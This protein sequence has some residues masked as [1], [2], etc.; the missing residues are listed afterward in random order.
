MNKQLH[1]VFAFLI[2]LMVSGC[3]SAFSTQPIETPLPAVKSVTLINPLGPLAI[4]ATGITSGLV[5]GE[6]QVNVQNWKTI[7]EA[8]GLL[9]SDQAQFAALPITNAANMQASG[10]NLTL[11]GVHEWKVFYLLASAKNEFRDW[12]SLIGKIIYLPEAKGQTVDILTRYALA[13]EHISE[14]DVTFVYAPPQEIVALFKEGKVE[15]TALPEPFV[16]QALAAAPGK[17]VLDYQ[18]YWSQVSGAKEGIPV[19]GLFVKRDFMARYPKV[20]QEVAQ[21]FSESITWAN[22]HPDDA[23]RVSS[24]ILPFPAEIMKSALTRLKFEYVPANQA[25]H[26]VLD[27]LITMQSTYP[28]GI[29]NIPDDA[30]FGE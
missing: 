16:S 2:L 5:K 23:L 8:T 30:F 11:L 28:A 29:K 15:Y 13:K 18:V 26:P 12:D 22:H 21:I 10:I 4:P 1:L 19:A 17:I 3:Q 25:K 24:T 27:F 7:D 6:I 14:K 9:A 20:A